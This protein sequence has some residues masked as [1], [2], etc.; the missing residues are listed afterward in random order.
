MNIND[1]K[2]LT[3]K[4][5]SIY[6]LSKDIKVSD[7]EIIEVIKHALTHTPSAFNTQLFRVVLLFNDKHYDFWDKT[8]DVLRKRSTKDFTKTELK[9]KSFKDAYGTILFF[10][11]SDVIKSLQEKMPS[12]AEHF[13][14]WAKQ[15]ISMLQYNIWLALTSLGLGVNLQH[16]NPLVDEFIKTDYL[17]NNSWKHVGEMVFGNPASNPSEKQF[18]PI[19]NKIK[20]FGL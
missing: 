6:N 10:E 5:R 3:E 15:D 16:Y 9:M 2:K 20:I 12:Y 14:T 4:R 18:V 19:E 7:E 8:E 17:D 11:D 1:F 13:S